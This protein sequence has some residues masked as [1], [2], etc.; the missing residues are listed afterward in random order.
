MDV[1]AFLDSVRRQSFYDG[2]LEHVEVLPERPGRYAEPTEPLPAQLGAVLAARGIERL[3]EHQV[4]ALEH[5]RAGRNVV[6]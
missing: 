2:Q 6:V 4:A 5:V 3:Y 1:A